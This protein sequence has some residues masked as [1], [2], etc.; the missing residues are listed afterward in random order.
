MAD[1][2]DYLV[3]KIATGVCNAPLVECKWGSCS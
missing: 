1:R 2:E 3:R